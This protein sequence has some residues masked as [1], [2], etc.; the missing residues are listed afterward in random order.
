[1]LL[2]S[3]VQAKYSADTPDRGEHQAW[4]E[5][6]VLSRTA[7]LDS[8][9]VDDLVNR[10]V[11]AVHPIK[12]IMFGS[13]A[14]GEMSPDSDI[15]VMV[16]VPD[17]THCLNTAHYLYK[18]MRGLGLPVDILVATPGTLAKHSENTGLI[19]R[20][21]LAEGKEIYVA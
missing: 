19:Y 2:L 20:T 3:L 15:D 16:V 17:G 13:A 11:K 12:I 8:R 21:V 7:Q 5:R 6:G 4:E 14:Q 1:L 18:Q 10:I 9:I